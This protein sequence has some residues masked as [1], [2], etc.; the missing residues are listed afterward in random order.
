[1]AARLRP[2]G[3]RPVGQRGAW[4]TITKRRDPIPHGGCLRCGTVDYE[5]TRRT[6]FCPDCRRDIDRVKAAER[7]R[8][9]RLARVVDRA[10]QVCAAELARPGLERFLADLLPFAV[11]DD[12]LCDWWLGLDAAERARLVEARDAQVS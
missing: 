6:P 12:E 2:V 9:L 11:V 7:M 5:P 1:M 10:A 8:R 3:L 4:A